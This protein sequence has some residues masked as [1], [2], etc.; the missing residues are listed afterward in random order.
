[1]KVGL[2]DVDGHNYPN[3]AL[4]KLKG[5][6]GEQ[7]EFY[8]VFNHY[9]VVYKAKV[10]TYTPDYE[11]FI[12]ADE[13]FYGGSG[14]NMKMDLFCD[15]VQPDYTLYKDFKF[16]DKNT[17]YGFV[18]RGCPNKCKWCIVPKKEGEIKPYDDVENISQGRRNIILM[19]NN[20]LAS[21]YGLSQLEKV[22]RNGYRIDLNQAMD[23]RLVT[24][25]IAQLIGNV[26]WINY[27]R[28]GCDTMQQVDECKRAIELIRKY[29]KRKTRFVLYT[30]IYGNI[31]DCYKRMHSF[32]DDRQVS[33]FAQPYRDFVNK[34]QK[35]PQW[36]KDM[37]H[38]ANRVYTYK[39]CDFKDFEV[40]KGFKCSEYL[41]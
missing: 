5:Y 10:F 19:D 20:I 26:H 28:F 29:N 22:V 38:W 11:Y 18:T 41:N 4:M 1:M 31:N 6:Y 13:V 12:N 2:I 32:R 34:S 15:N 24:D 25:E 3:L 7:A 40:R 21:D 27:I 14:Y 33:I 39:T 17:A 30:M 9:D 16:Y 8:S 35:I 37:A 36:Q 23:A